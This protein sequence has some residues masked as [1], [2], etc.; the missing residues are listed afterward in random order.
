MFAVEVRDHIM[1]AHSLPAP[2]FG[3]AQGVHGA[4]FV[5]DAAFFAEE[6]DRARHRRRHRHRDRPA[7][8]GAGAAALQEPRRRA[9]VRR[10]HDHDRGPRPPRLR[11]ARRR[12]P[13]RTLRGRRPHPPHSRDPPRKPRRPRLVRGRPR[14]TRSPVER[15]APEPPLTR[16][17]E[18]HATRPFPHARSGPRTRLGFERP[19]P[20]PG[21]RSRGTVGLRISAVDEIRMRPPPEG[22]RIPRPRGGHTRIWSRTG[23]PHP[24]S[25]PR[26]RAATNGPAEAMPRLVGPR[27]RRGQGARFDLKWRVPGDHRCTLPAPVV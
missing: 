10:P 21:C 9:G 20:S 19:C 24:P 18:R 17:Y 26:S 4:T 7:L 12:G 3:P 5:V 23:L 11:C 13:G 15:S 8:R 16:V 25:S 2:V 1:I 6:L 22:G 27:T 14:V